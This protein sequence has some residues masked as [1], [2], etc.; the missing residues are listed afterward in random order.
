MQTALYADFFYYYAVKSVVLLML[1]AHLEDESFLGSEKWVSFC[2]KELKSILCMFSRIFS[3]FRS[4]ALCRQPCTQTSSITTP[5]PSGTARSSFSP[6]HSEGIGRVEG[7][8]VV[9]SFGRP[10]IG[11]GGG[12]MRLVFS[13]RSFLSSQIFRFDKFLM[14]RASFSFSVCFPPDL[15]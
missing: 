4:E 13:Q 7:R 6:W 15:R 5:R 14:M 10:F 3:I 2:L 1:L 11:W 8:G 12:G 9:C